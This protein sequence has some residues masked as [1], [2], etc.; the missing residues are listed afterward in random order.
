[1]SHHDQIQDPGNRG[2]IRQCT[3]RRS[4][5]KQRE[6]QM[7]DPATDADVESADARL[8][9]SIVLGTSTIAATDPTWLS[10]LTRNP[11]LAI[12]CNLLDPFD[13]LCE[14]PIR[15]Q[16]LLRHPSAKSVGEPVFRIDEHTNSVLFQSLHSQASSMPLLADKASF[17][18]LSLLLA[19]AANGHKPN[20]E[21]I[22]HHGQ[23]LESLNLDLSHS[24]AGVP[25]LQTVT[26]ILML[27][28]YEY[29]VQDTLPVPTNA[30]THIHGL[31]SIINQRS[32]SASEH[33]HARIKQIQRALFWQ[34]II[35]SLATGT[36]RLLQLENHDFFTR[37]REDQTYRS[38]FALPQG[39]KV[40]ADG[41]P[42]TSST[43]FEDLNAMCRLVDRI[44]GQERTLLHPDHDVVSIPLMEDLDDEGYPVYNSQAN[45][46]IR[47]V[48]LLS[49]T[50]RSST[51][52]QEDLIYRA[53][54]FAAYLC[55]YRL[56]SG[57]WA[58]HFAP[59]ICV[60]E[61]LSCMTAF[62]RHMS[63]WNFAPAV[64]FWLLHVAGGLTKSQLH[65]DQAAVLV[66][67]YRSFY[68]SGYSLDW[69]VVRLKLKEFI[70]CERA[71]A[72]S[73]NNFWQ[74]C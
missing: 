51:Q 23:V 34:D 21:T 7:S 1:M 63:P 69:E 8:P 39:F 66:K 42:A 18:A 47:L 54:L 9:D 71:M 3:F 50:A 62:T 68:S 46:E 32:I 59:E 29:R 5:Q 52:K 48:D 4:I 25:S 31:Q 44:H 64:S 13:T 38:Y 30:A 22:Y 11:L 10:N 28:S 15:L 55:T 20:Y 36:P 61:I 57:L 16:Q 26:A 27:I 53:C 58:G 19:L 45:L 2:G 41:W 72:K 49:K 73:L 43:V 6:R 60:T 67:R 56:S 33:N 24:D 74:Q 37:L 40:H 17:H 14:S 35:C 65:K 12:S 70:W